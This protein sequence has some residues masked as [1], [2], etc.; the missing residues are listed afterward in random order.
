MRRIVLIALCLAAVP[1]ACKTT[2]PEGTENREPIQG[3]TEVR[4]PL[5]NVPATQPG[6][7]QPMPGVDGG[8]AGPSEPG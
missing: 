3:P 4:E 8:N 2:Q 1:L 5:Q 7:A 6:P